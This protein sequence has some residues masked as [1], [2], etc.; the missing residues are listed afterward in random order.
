VKISEV[1]RL[2]VSDPEL[3]PDLVEFLQSR[4]DVLT[5]RVA[6]D[7]VEVALLAPRETPPGLT[8]DLLVRAWEALRPARVRL[9]A[10]SD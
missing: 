6:K 3:V 8:L 9:I 2:G 1:V 4:A 5:A 10:V 7:E